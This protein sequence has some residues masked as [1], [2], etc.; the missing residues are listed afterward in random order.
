MIDIEI[1]KKLVQVNRYSIRLGV[2]RADANYLRNMQQQNKYMY[3]EKFN[4][5][6]SSSCS[7][8]Q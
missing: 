3:N 1:S 4:A 8:F 5:V 6:L 2:K 7:F